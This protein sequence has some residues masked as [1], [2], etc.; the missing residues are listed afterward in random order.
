[1]RWMHNRCIECPVS[2]DDYVLVLN[3]DAP[4][5]RLSDTARRRLEFRYQQAVSPIGKRAVIFRWAAPQDVDSQHPFATAVRCRMSAVNYSRSDVVVRRGAGCGRPSV[6]FGFRCQRGGRGGWGVPPPVPGRPRKWSPN[7]G[8]W[9][10]A[11][12]M[13]SRVTWR[14]RPVGWRHE[15]E[16]STS[17]G[18]TQVGMNKKR[19]IIKNEADN[20]AL[21]GVVSYSVAGTWAPSA[22]GQKRPKILSLS[23]KVCQ[24]RREIWKVNNFDGT[25]SSFYRLGPSTCFEKLRPSAP[26]HCY[27][28]F[29]AFGDHMCWSNLRSRSKK[30]KPNSWFRS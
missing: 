24:T 8:M 10:E 11:D 26:G 2:T 13:V 20:S 9:T 17:A 15:H 22:W 18:L 29:W 6:Q 28:Q 14:H 5:C 1:M 25:L 27:V 23:K 12:D 21:S 19:K 30:V 7:A 16:Q 3:S 4:R